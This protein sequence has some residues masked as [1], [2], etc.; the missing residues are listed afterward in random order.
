M[1]YLKCTKK[2]LDFAGIKADFIPAVMNEPTDLGSWYV[3]MFTVDR[4]KTLIFMNERTLMSFIAYGVKKSN[5][6]DLRPMFFGGLE[7]LLQME[8][9]PDDRMGQIIK[10]Y[11]DTRY[12]KTDS[13]TSLGNMN[14][15]VFAYKLFILDGG[16]FSHCGV[17]E[18]IRRVNRTPQRNLG[19][20]YSIDAMREILDKLPPT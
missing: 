10:S 12:S 6:S 9:V 2:V 8:K 4:K 18:I 13:R 5:C 17:G 19:G 14:D 1:L 3:N 7:Q 16:G 20:R 15:L 11:A